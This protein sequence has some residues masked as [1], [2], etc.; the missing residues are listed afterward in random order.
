MILIRFDRDDHQRA[1][2]VN[3]EDVS[4]VCD[5]S[6]SE[7]T[8]NPVEIRFSGQSS[9]N[10]SIHVPGPVELVVARLTAHIPGPASSSLDV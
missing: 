1:I 3:P 2:Y 4:A 8:L 10:Y 5:T 9:L 6:V 7:N